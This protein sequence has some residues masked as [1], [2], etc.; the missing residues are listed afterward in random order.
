MRRLEV[1]GEVVEHGGLPRRDPMRGHEALIA[2]SLGLRHKIGGVNI[3]DRF[4]MP[5]KAQTLDH[6][7]GMLA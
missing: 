2:G 7:F 3:E 6:P 1:V 5:L 4:E